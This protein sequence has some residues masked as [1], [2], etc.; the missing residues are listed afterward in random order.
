[1]AQTTR[2]ALLLIDVQN[3]YVYGN[4]PIEHPPV[5]VSLANIGRAMD[6]AESAAIPVVVVQN[7]LPETAPF[8]AR[9]TKGADLHQVVASRG[10]DHYISKNMPSA[11]QGTDLED[12]LR[13]RLI[14]T[15]TIAGYMTHNCDLSTVLHAF[16][17]GFKVEVL[18]DATGSLPYANQAGNATA[19][20]IHRVMLVV[21]QARFAAVMSTG[22]WLRAITTGAEPERDT[23]FFSNQRARKM[24]AR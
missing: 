8:M 13:E 4:L 6:G 1:M 24:T 16:H 17:A 12:W 15:I 22:A 2:R 20:E 9:G 19:E 7:L 18:S 14:D 5:E 21:M 11:F 10:R 3:D 23:I